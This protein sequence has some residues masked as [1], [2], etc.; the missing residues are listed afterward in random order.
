MY[1]LILSEKELN[2]LQTIIFEFCNSLDNRKDRHGNYK[3]T[4]WDDCLEFNDYWKNNLKK[5]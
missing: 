5:E 2:T 1:K 4:T 3:N